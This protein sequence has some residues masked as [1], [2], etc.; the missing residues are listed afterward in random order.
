MPA[1][2]RKINKANHGRRPRNHKAR[3]KQKFC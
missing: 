3:R 1:N 2:S